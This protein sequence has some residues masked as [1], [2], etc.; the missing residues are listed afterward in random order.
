MVIFIWTL[1]LFFNVI[2][3]KV[4]YKYKNHKVAIFNTF[5]SV[6]VFVVLV[7]ALKGYVTK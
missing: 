3:A 2:S 7:L 5:T 6:I 1:L 4:N